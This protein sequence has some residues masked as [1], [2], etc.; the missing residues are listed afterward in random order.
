[1]CYTGGHAKAKGMEKNN[2]YA[3]AVFFDNNAWVEKSNRY[4]CV[5][6]V[7]YMHAWKRQMVCSETWFIFVPIFQN[8]GKKNNPMHFADP[9]LS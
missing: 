7:I 3:C 4:A 6:S 8:H 1:M 5:A 2:R 9:T